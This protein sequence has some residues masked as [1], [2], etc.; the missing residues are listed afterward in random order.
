MTPFWS[1]LFDHLRECGRNATLFMFALAGFFSLLI[2]A[3][4]VCNTEVRQYALPALAIPGIL[5]LIWLGREIRRARAR[6]RERLQ[7]GPLSYD[8]LRVAREK[9]QKAKLLREQQ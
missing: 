2:L 1:G 5:A 7:R 9:L 6:H 8:E 3:A 4:V